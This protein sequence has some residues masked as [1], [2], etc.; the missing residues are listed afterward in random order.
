MIFHYLI[1][2]RVPNINKSH[3][4]TS[5]EEILLFKISLQY[6]DIFFAASEVA[7]QR[8]SQEKVFWKYEANLQENTRAK[9][10]FQ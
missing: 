2:Y 9:V 6:Q 7:T 10:R 1:I 4:L 5:K 8:C 3:D